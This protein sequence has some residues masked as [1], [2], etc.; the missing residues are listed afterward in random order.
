MELWRWHGNPCPPGQCILTLGMKRILTA[1]VLIP[2]VL[3]V[4]FL[5]RP[6]LVTVLTA[7]VSALAA[8]EYLGLAERAGPSPPRIAVVVAITALFVGNFNYPNQTGDLF[9]ILSL[10]LLVYCTFA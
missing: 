5:G 1:V 4:V 2:L 6:W 7:V 9:G 8:W 10:G 3:T